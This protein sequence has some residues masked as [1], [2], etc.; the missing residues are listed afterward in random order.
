[1]PSIERDLGED[2]QL[3][4]DLVGRWKHYH[5][6]LG[7]RASAY[8]RRHQSGHWYMFGTSP[9]D[10]AGNS[11]VTTLATDNPVNPVYVA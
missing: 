7:P 8:L 4:Y 1:M 10:R 3:T 11:Y 6:G 5:Y 2:I 9:E